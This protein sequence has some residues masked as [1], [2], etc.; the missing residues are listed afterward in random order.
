MG[1]TLGSTSSATTPTVAV[2]RART[3]VP[4]GIRSFAG[5][6]AGAVVDQVLSSGAQL[7]LLVLVARRA[8]AT[9]FGAL[10]VALIVHGFLLGVMRAAIGEVVLLRCRAQPS[11]RRGE[12]C[13]GLFLALLAGAG[14]AVGLLAVSVVVGGEV[15]HFLL[16]VALAAPL[17]YPQ[18][19]IR[20]VAYGAE[21][22][23]Q[24]ILVDGVWLGLQV[25]VSAVLL[26]YGEATPT[27]LVLAWVAGAGAA[28]VVG[29]RVQRLRPLPVGLRAWWTDERARA[30]GFLS[31]FL[32]STGV[33][34]GAFILL[35]VLLPLDE[36]GVLRVAIVA[37]S[38]LAS[39]LAGV[40]IL[41][42]ARLGGLRDRPAQ[43]HRW[44]RH[45]G[46]GFG[47][48]AAAYG[49]GLV[50]LPES[51]GS[52]VFGTTWAEASSI[53]GIVALAE[54]LRLGT[55]PAID[56]VKVL[57]QPMDLVRT[58]LV[59]GA[60]AVTGLL[61][62]A[63]VAGPRGAAV[64]GVLSSTLTAITWWRQ[65]RI[66]RRRAAMRVPAVRA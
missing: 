20:Y 64:G 56:L 1:Q 28:A 23:G 48:A 44:A 53:V 40:R 66:V 4:G 39:V 29:V 18:D 37:L 54:T 41:T 8:D 45:M 36:F 15:G 2:R 11:A 7:L 17:V 59:T 61:L 6:T 3:A 38:P 30:G 5:R 58:R 62:G 26:A 49:V 25:A 21:R 63:A 32:V 55:L 57:G 52:E 42:L 27:R 50:L 10:S 60:G 65:A 33:T 13:L 43:A 9:T 46:L 19:L 14:A 51:W 47:G 24:A 16:L 35:S 22:L 12:A 34:Q 31:D